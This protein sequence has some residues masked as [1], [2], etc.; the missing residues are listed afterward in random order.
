V[1]FT[2]SLFSSDATTDQAIGGAETAAG[3]TCGSMC[4]RNGGNSTNKGTAIKSTI[5]FVFIVIPF[6]SFG[7]VLKNQLTKKSYFDADAASRI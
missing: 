2:V 4:V 3:C 1:R 7:M 6:L 5:R